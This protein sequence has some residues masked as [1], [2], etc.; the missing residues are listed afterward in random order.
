MFEERH[1]VRQLSQLFQQLESAQKTNL[2]SEA[3]H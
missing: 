3:Q 2:P 1:E